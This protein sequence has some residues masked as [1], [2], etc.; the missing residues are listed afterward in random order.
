MRILYLHPRAWSGEYSLLRFLGTRGHEICVLEEWRGERRPARFVSQDFFGAGDGIRT[1]WYDMHR[2]WEKIFTWPLDRFFKRAFSGRNLVH[3]MWIVLDAVKRFRPDVVICSD[4]FTYAIPAAFLKRLGLLRTPLIASY[5]GGDI[6]D[7]PEA[8]VGK[9][10]AGLTDWIIRASYP[11]FDR[12]RPVS[13][14]LAAILLR[15][16]VA[17]ERIAIVPSHLTADADVLKG[18]SERKA[19]LAGEIRAR[20][21]FPPEAPLLI[22]LSP[23]HKG[24]GLHLLAAQW[25]RICAAVPGIRWLLCGPAD[26]WLEQAVIP[27]VREA[28]LG[29][30]LAVAGRLTGTE[31]YE[32]LAAADLH[33]AP[34]LCESLNMAAVEAAAVG[35]PTVCGDGAGIAAWL[36]RFAAGAV[37]PSGNAPALGDAIIAAFADPARVAAWRANCPAMAA[38]FSLVRI[39]S[40]LERLIDACHVR[41]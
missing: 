24:K 20:N 12:L 13:P 31:V 38:E 3:R 11:A 27:A 39:A 21:G 1:L 26:P 35:T 30:S 10:R 7:C 14:K 8:G 36:E 15:D 29:A 5:I 2:G 17:R 18:V 22:T 4:G 40:D 41:N 33:V 37:V 16:G 28:G 32:H 9:R 34:S 19:Q 23:N 25:P 6:L